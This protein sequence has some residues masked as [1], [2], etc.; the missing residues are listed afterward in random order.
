MVASVSGVQRSQTQTTNSILQPP[1]GTADQSRAR[2]L[3][4]KPVRALMICNLFTLPYR[5]MRC[6]HAAGAHVWALG[7]QGAHGLQYSRYCQKFIRAENEFDGTP[8][9]GAAEEINRYVQEL[10]IDLVMAGDA[11]STRTLIALQHAVRARCFPM[12][13]LSWFDTLN[14]KWEFTKICRRLDIRCPPTRLLPDREAALAEITAGRQRMPAIAK[15]LSLE[16]GH[17]VIKLD[18][19]GFDQQIKA[20]TY[21]PVLLQDFI[22][23][24]D[25]GASV[26]CQS[27]RVLSFI[28][29]K[30]ARKTYTVF[31]SNEIRD[32][33]TRIMAY[34][35]SDGVYNFDM[36]RTVDG[37]IFFLECNPRFFYKINLSMVAGINFAQPGIARGA[38]LPDLV[39]DGRRVRMPLAFAADLCKPWTL[40]FRDL[41]MMRYLYSDPVSMVREW[42]RIDWED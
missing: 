38:A 11:P 21:T 23:G 35:G 34:A 32:A 37:R 12:P 40:S 33:V 8:R 31:H 19:A 22:E 42:L 27:G 16:G 41:A 39:P 29:H 25:I 14:N 15:P 3:D 7:N 17:G 20:V 13:D 28:A 6:A 10:D 2:N 30:L 36:R 18:Y 1:L 24:E 26:Y 9:P 5:V 4:T